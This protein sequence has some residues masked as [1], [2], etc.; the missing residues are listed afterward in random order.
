[1][2]AAKLGSRGDDPR[3]WWG[4]PALVADWAAVGILISSVNPFVLVARVKDLNG[5]PSGVH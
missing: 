5:D 2:M 4:C 3:H 1:M